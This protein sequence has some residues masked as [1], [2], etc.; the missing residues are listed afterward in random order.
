MNMPEISRFLTNT[1]EEFIMKRLILTIL[2]TSTSILNICAQWVN[3]P[4]GTT[5]KLFSVYFF[6]ENTGWAVGGIYAGSAVIILKTTNGG[7][8]WITKYDSINNVLHSVQF[9]NENTGWA[10]GG[11]LRSLILK[12][13]DGGM[14]WYNPTSEIF[15]Y[16]SSICFLDQNT[17][18]AVDEYYNGIIK[19]T[20]GGENW[21]YQYNG[22]TLHTVFFIDYN[23][24]WAVGDEGLFNGNVIRTTNGGENW[25]YQTINFVS[26]LRSVFFIN[27]STGW[28]IGYGNNKILKSTTGGIDWFPLQYNGASIP[29]SVF[30]TDENNGWVA[31]GYGISPD[32][33]RI[34]KTTNG[35]LNWS[36]QYDAEP[37]NGFNSIFFINQYTGWAVGSSGNILKTT[38]GGSLVG[39]SENI[40]VNLNYLLDQNYPNPFNPSTKINYSL[41]VTQH[42]VL[43]IYNVLGHEIATLVNEKKNAGSYFIE[44]NGSNFPSGIYFYQIWAGDFTETRRMLLI[45]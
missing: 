13:I 2:I 22:Y 42:T 18:W 21:I 26:S 3:Q 28:T 40:G 29:N 24:G 38:N 43:K 37:S 45:K 11:T 41:P 15:G 27:H 9:V 35:G 32:P 19:T 1:I 23:T 39:I 36:L 5:K 16:L 33:A 17:G 8:N 10:V 25:S 30:F 12:S 20:N 6:N 34:I 31:G 44:F 7:E 14:N 4:S